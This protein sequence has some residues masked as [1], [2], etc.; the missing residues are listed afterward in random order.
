MDT[1]HTH[2]WALGALVD[3]DQR[4]K[5]HIARDAQVT[6][7]QLGDLISGRRAG[8]NPDVRARLAAA[9]H[10]D[11]RSLTCWCDNRRDNHGGN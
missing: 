8:H 3:R 7:Q 11:V 10:V 4:T 6:P 2:N 1:E 5:A 9:L